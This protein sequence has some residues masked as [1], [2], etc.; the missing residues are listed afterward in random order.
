MSVIVAFIG[1]KIFRHIPEET[2]GAHGMSGNTGQLRGAGGS[3]KTDPSIS[4]D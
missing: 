3:K 1:Y 2:T 4:E